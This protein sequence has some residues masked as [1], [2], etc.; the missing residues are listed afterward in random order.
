MTTGDKIRKLRIEKGFTQEELGK[1]LGVGKSAIAKYENNRVKNLKK[2]TII[3]LSEIFEV[4]PDYL[5]TDAKTVFT[6]GSEKD[7][8]AKLFSEGLKYYGYTI[9]EFAEYAEISPLVARELEY[10]STNFNVHHI[11]KYCDFLKFDISTFWDYATASYHGELDPDVTIINW[12][13]LMKYNNS[14]RESYDKKKME[15]L[16]SFDSFS[17]QDQS[18]LLVDFQMIMELKKHKKQV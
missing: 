9:D 10:D 1:K 18:D 4:S 16:A 6:D 17:L 2:Y 3:K 8:L 15:F 12:L 13:E 7:G 11:Q 14:I 5:Y